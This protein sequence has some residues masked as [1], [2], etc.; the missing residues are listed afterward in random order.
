MIDILIPTRGRPER[1]SKTIL[2]AKKKCSGEYEITYYVYVDE[3]DLPTYN[4]L[5]HWIESGGKNIKY[6]SD[7]Q[8]ILSQC[9]NDLYKLGT[10][11]ILFHGADDIIFETQDWDLKVVEHFK[12]HPESLYYGQDGHQDKNCPTHSF[13][14]RSAADKIGYF[15]PPYFEADWNDVW[16]GEVYNKLGRRFYDE[17]LMIRHNHVNVDAK[18]DDE[19][20]ELA[21]ERRQRSSKV[22][23]EKKHL[24]DEDVK[25]LR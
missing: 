8:Q 11:E 16:L 6:I 13:T 9:W 24:I 20:Y 22:W 19:T 25:K 7:K 14:S 3:D 23:E 2:S 15:V 1:L 10:G 4:L 21:R 18:F 5:W 17:T 12:K